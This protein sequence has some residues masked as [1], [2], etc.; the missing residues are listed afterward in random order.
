MAGELGARSAVRFGSA[1]S[2]SII[3]CTV[4]IIG[5]L[6]CLAGGSCVIYDLLR[7]WSI[8]AAP[9]RELLILRLE[10]SL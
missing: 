3:L 5:P 1:T 6:G 4:H 9:V 2:L 8:Q 10:G 7:L